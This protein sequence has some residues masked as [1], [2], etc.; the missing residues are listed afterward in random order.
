M[1]GSVRSRKGIRHTSA[2]EMKTKPTQHSVG[3]L[4]EIGIQP[5]I[6]ICRTEKRLTKEIRAKIGL[7][8]NI[9]DDAVI[10]E[11]DVDHTIY[12]LPLMLQ[13]HGL[14]QVVL[15][16]LNLK[17]RNQ[18]SL[19]EWKKVVCPVNSDPGSDRPNRGSE[20]DIASV[21]NHYKHI[22]RIG[23]HPFFW[24]SDRPG[25]RIVWNWD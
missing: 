15:R 18:A 9:S 24:T 16:K 10:E 2:Q 1:P 17:P 13:R 22:Y 11:K 14:D 25:S 23:A 3:K 8:C 19:T 20:A 5:D 21:H 7:F 12:E 6:L 4:R